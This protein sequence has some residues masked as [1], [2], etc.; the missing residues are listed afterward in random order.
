MNILDE[1]ILES[2]RQLLLKWRVPF[3]QIGMEVGRKGMKDEEIIPFLLTLPRLTFFSVDPDFCKRNL[4]HARYGLVFLDVAQEE[5]AIFVRRVLHHPEF[6][7]QAK[8][9]GA[10]IRASHAGLVVWRLRGERE[11]HFD[12]AA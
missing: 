5:A 12:W 9:I 10:V 8:R 2:Q 11:V 6:D 1:N 3:R 7:A 4:C